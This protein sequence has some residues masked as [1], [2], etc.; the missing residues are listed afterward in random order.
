MVNPKI[1]SQLRGREMGDR[2]SPDISPLDEKDAWMIPPRSWN[3]K[4]CLLHVEMAK[5]PSIKILAKWLF[6][7]FDAADM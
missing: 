1:K 2:T 6:F 7:H 5:C 3:L 4:A